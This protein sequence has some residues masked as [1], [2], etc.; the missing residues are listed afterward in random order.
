LLGRDTMVSS[1]REERFLAGL[2]VVL[3]ATV[4]M[5]ELGRSPVAWLWLGLNVLLAASAWVARPRRIA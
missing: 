3:G 4:L 2:L 5:Q 1:L